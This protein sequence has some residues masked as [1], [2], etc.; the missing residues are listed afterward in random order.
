MAVA[1]LA[2][3]E[4]L[5]SA[6]VADGLSDQQK[7]DPDRELFGQGLANIA[8]GFFGGMPATG[9]IARTAVN[10]RAGAQ[11]RLSAAFH[12]VVLVVA[13]LIAAS[14]LA[15]I[16]LPVLA[17]ILLFT[18]FRMVEPHAVKAIV[19]STRS[20]AS[21]F[22]VTALATVLLDLILAVEIGIVIAATLAIRTLAANSHAV[23][24]ELNPEMLSDA[25]AHN[26]LR[27]HIGIYRIDGALFFGAAQK[28]L[29]ELT[30]LNQL[31]VM[32]LRLDFVSHMDATGAAT[33]K[34]VIQDLQRRGVVVLLKSV[35]PQ[36][37]MMLEKIGVCHLLRSKGDSFQHLADAV[38]EAER[39][40]RANQP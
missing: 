31:Q 22:L 7:S 6:K 24:E 4:S 40:V 3:I 8:S 26:L 37:Q 11:T 16:P 33:L 25:E 35:K 34:E 5:L 13:V 27:N 39:I 36:H 2:A 19:G 14:L 12:A 23:V 17:G 1:A 32:I 18:A 21:V 20:D 15:E 29:E 38:A 10:I 30:D 28:F 9:A